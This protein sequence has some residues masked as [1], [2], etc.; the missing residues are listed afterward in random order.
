MIL[1]LMNLGTAL[2]ITKGNNYY[3]KETL[4]QMKRLSNILKYTPFL[5]LY[6]TDYSKEKPAYLVYQL[7]C[8]TP[9][10]YGILYDKL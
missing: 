3:L 2:L 5:G 4:L 10:V 1:V 6:F 8:M 7:L 9:I